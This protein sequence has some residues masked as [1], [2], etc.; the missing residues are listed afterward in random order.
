MAC[1]ITLQPVGILYRKPT[2][3]SS[4]RCSVIPAYN[5]PMKLLAPLIIA[6]GLGLTLAFADP[7]ENG[8]E[9]R[10]S[11]F[12]PT[13]TGWENKEKTHSVPDA[14]GTLG[15]L[16]LGMAAIAFWRLKAA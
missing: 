10:N 8:L 1:Q 14:G 2:L 5:W 15:L 4:L 16:S 11:D 7:S 12:N 13:R 9:H 3:Y 6:A